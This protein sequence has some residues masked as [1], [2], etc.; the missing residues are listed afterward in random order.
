MQLIKV[1]SDEDYNESHSRLRG[2]IEYAF[3]FDLQVVW[4]S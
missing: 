2:V 3:P 4:R 1:G